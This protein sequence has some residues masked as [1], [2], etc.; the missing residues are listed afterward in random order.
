MSDRSDWW[1]STPPPRV[2][3]VRQIRLQTGSERAKVGNNKGAFS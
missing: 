1:E 3:T 2:S